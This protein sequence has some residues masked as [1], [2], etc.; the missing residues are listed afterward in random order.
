MSLKTPDSTATD[1]GSGDD[2]QS[3]GRPRDP[4]IDQAI[5]DATRRR[6]VIDG[7]TKMTIGDVAR[8]AGV[9][10]P[11]IY[12]RWNDKFGLVVDSLDYG[13]RAQRA[14]YP[15]TQF[16]SLTGF[17]AFVEAIRRVDPC[18][19]NPDAMV[20]VGNFMGE[21]L[22]TPELLDM[23]REHAV[24][25]RVFMVEKLLLALQK[26]GEVRLDADI[27]TVATLSFGAYYAAFLR[28]ENDRSQLAMQVASTLWPAI[29]AK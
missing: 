12:R 6:L 13:F 8:E 27:H 10:R 9:T 26:K 15:T 25:P 2:A 1:T 5:I 11:T 21:K 20:L 16:D 29:S 7:Y 24:E 14:L 17:D 23:F 4:A 28:G 18:Y 19:F 22:R 3:R